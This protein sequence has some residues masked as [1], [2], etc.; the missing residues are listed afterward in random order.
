MVI[1]GWKGWTGPAALLWFVESR[2][3]VCPSPGNSL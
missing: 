2:V 1:F 3:C